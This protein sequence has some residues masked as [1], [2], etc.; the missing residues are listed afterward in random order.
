MI[1]TYSIYMYLL[2]GIGWTTE[3][4]LDSHG[5]PLSAK[6]PQPLEWWECPSGTN[7]PG[8]P[9][10]PVPSSGKTETSFIFYKP[11]VK[12]VTTSRW[13]MMDNGPWI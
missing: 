3:Q 11:L 2:G 7:T 6:Q 9:C 5:A 12:Q 13:T 4:P 1:V 10:H 8:D